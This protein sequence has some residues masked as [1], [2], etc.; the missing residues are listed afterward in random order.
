MNDKVKVQ[1]I[2]GPYDGRIKR[3]WYFETKMF[4]PHKTDGLSPEVYER[5]YYDEFTY[6]GSKHVVELM[7]EW[8]E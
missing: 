8:G 3:I 7:Q 2:G 6:V 4:L 5:T 1:L